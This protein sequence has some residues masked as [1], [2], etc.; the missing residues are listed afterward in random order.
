MSEFITLVVFY[1][2]FALFTTH[3]LDAIQRHEWRIFPITRRLADEWAYPLFTAVHIPLYVCLLWLFFH[4][5][6]AVALN[7]RA[8]FAAFAIIHAGLHWLLRHHPKYE[9]N[10]RFSWTI[11]LSTAVAGLFYLLLVF[12]T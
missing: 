5:N 1:L 11:I 9:F 4:T 7:S 2:L 10:N 8:A 6:S 12:V 3:E